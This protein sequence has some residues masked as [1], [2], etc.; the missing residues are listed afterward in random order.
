MF[1]VKLMKFTFLCLLSTLFA[2]CKSVSHRNSYQSDESTSDSGNVENIVDVSNNPNALDLASL[3]NFF[4]ISETVKVDRI[5][6]VGSN[7]RNPSVVDRQNKINIALFNKLPV[8]DKQ[9]VVFTSDS[10]EDVDRIVANLKEAYGGDSVFYP[11]GIGDLSSEEGAIAAKSNSGYFVY[12]KST[13]GVKITFLSSLPKNYAP[14]KP[15]P[16]LYTE[17]GISPSVSFEALAIAFQEKTGSMNNMSQS[18]EIEALNQLAVNST[19][20]SQA[21]NELISNTDANIKSN[22]ANRVPEKIDLSKLASEDQVNTFI[23]QN[24]KMNKLASLF[25]DISL[26]YSTAKPYQMQKNVLGNRIQTAFNKSLPVYNGNNDLFTLYAE[27]WASGKRGDSLRN[28]VISRFTEKRTITSSEGIAGIKNQLSI[29]LKEQGASL[30]EYTKVDSYVKGPINSFEKSIRDLI[31]SE[32]VS[33]EELAILLY[34]FDR[35]DFIF[36]KISEN[37]APVSINGIM[38][39]KKPGFNQVQKQFFQQLKNSQK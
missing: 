35:D 31:R 6:G 38:T 20:Y 10:A 16:T 18:E 36:G 28:A 30:E 25:S 14:P 37:T 17:L 3:R 5:E 12:K 29:F 34:H 24:Q 33:N 2:S 9:S 26:A 1:T 11:D 19:K 27:E 23:Q 22:L 13:L 32:R 39:E 21:S 8:K 15:K 4:G 7:A